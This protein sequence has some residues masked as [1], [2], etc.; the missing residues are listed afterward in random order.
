MNL[1]HLF[2]MMR[3]LHVFLFYLI[4]I[5]TSS[6]AT[7]EKIQISFEGFP[8]TNQLP[9]NTV[10]RVYQDND[11]YMWFGTLD[12]LC[13]YDAYH[14]RTFRS[15]MY[16]PNLLSNN[17]ILCITEDQENN[18]WFGTKEGLNILNK[19]NFKITP[20]NDS[21]VQG[22][23]INGLASDKDGNMWIGLQNGTLL[24][25]NTHNQT[26]DK[27]V[28]DPKNKRSIPEGSINYI[29]RDNS[30]NIWIMFWRDG[31][32][33]YDP[34]T[35]SFQHYPF[36]GDTNNP[37]R[38]YQDKQN[39]YWICTWGDGFFHFD[40]TAPKDK[41]YTPYTILKDGKNELE[42]TFFSV[43]QDDKYGYLWLMSLSGLHVL[44]YQED[45][46]LQKIDISSY[47]KGTSRIFSEIIKDRD[48]NL[49][50][51]TFSEGIILINFEKP[52]IL[53]YPLDVLKQ[54][55]GYTPSIK[56]IQKDK[57]GL[58]WLGLNRIGLCFYDDN[59][60]SATLYKEIPEFMHIREMETINCIREIKSLNEYWVA[61]NGSLIYIFK[62]NGKNNIYLSETLNLGYNND[63]HCYGDK[64]IFED[65]QGNVW[66]GLEKGVLVKSAGKP[67]RTTSLISSVTD[68]TQ[69]S[70]GNIWVSSEKDGLI[71]L[72]REQKY[73]VSRTLNKK[74]KE[75]NSSNIQAVHGHSSGNIWIGTKEGRI[76]TYDKEN[77]T[78]EDVSNLC[79]M[80]GEAILNLTEDNYGNI[81]ISTNKKITKFNPKSNTSIYYSSSDGVDI[82]FIIDAFTNN[83]HT[84]EVLFGGNKGFC[85]F[86]PS[87]GQVIKSS[88]QAKV[89]IS[90]IR[91]NNQS[92]FDPESYG[93]FD[94][95]SNRLMVEHTGK[96]IE[97]EFSSLNYSF[98]HR[99]QYAYKMEG[100][101][102][103]WIYAVNNRRFASYNNLERG[104][105]S[106]LLKAT[107]ENGVWNDAVTIVEIYK[108]PAFYESWWAYLFYFLTIATLLVIIYRF[109]INKLK[110]SEEL[111]ITQIEKE[112]AEELTQTKLRYFTNISHELLTPLTIVSCLIE[113]LEGSSK[114][115][116]WQFKVMRSNIN[117][118]KRLLQQILDFRK[119]ESGNMKLKIK[120]ND[121]IFFLR[122]ICDFNFMPLVKEKKINFSFT[123][124]EDKLEAWFDADKL[125]KII[126]NLL[127][128]AFK[129]TPNGGDIQ[130]NV[131]PITRDENTYARII[132]SDTGKGIP[133]DDL[134][135]IFTR[136]FSNEFTN[137]VESN[138]I[139]LSLTKELIEMHHGTIRVE[140]ELGSGTSFIIEF[141]INKNAYK[142]NELSDVSLSA[143]Q[144]EMLF[145]EE[146]LSIQEESDHI[147]LEDVNI[148]VVEDN[149]HLRSLINK[150]FHKR[151]HTF[152]AENGRAALKIIEEKQIDL[153]ISDVIMPEMDGLEL[154]RII[155]NNIPTSHIEVLLLTAKNSIDDRIECYNAGAD[156][157]I[158]KPFE[159][160]VLEAKVNSLIKNKKQKIEGFKSD[161]ELNFSSLE[162]TPLDKKFLNDAVAVIKEHIS[163]SDFDLGKFADKLNMSKSSLYRKIK[164]LTGL[165]P[166]E[167]TKN[168]K[169]KRA[170]I[171][172]KE[173]QGSVSEIAYAVGFSDPKYFAVCFKS[174][175]GMT[176]T[177][178]IKTV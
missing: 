16:R 123:S 111:K 62:K 31:L 86:L 152:S 82:S 137:S 161:V 103:E 55:L 83:K 172:L 80:T 155:K 118:L 25:Y 174:E 104:N 19:S 64:T 175:F 26:T 142:E 106:F 71:T 127:S 92:V 75:L 52:P 167:F 130:V 65:R 51:G 48:G 1:F 66:I 30:N 11:G 101:D 148:L 128:N 99:I 169:L 163:E 149:E 42:S 91:I 46:S 162:Y 171:L 21:I 56:A 87:N 60:N 5:S 54:K 45:H 4:F 23:R 95:A 69:D 14:L 59:A 49:W 176:P 18:L 61:C 102:N 84:G 160:K 96:N 73:S 138:G 50:I 144:D 158:S 13:R 58:I 57:D 131:E 113:D 105:Y 36:L 24:K 121:I 44:N 40:P 119:V 132:V 107:D 78:F 135:N 70:D 136:F 124:S 126:F 168:I 147:F 85:S 17:E 177:E 109:S 33:K 154:C 98:P 108:K 170:C 112:K 134:E 2:A 38:L 6:L 146:E 166:V 141:P 159:L 68:I 77:H 67:L 133:A 27:Y 12:G 143:T 15:D 7:E 156:G 53:T 29:Y 22:E 165:S 32:C 43:I 81:W 122:Q 164:S 93:S 173:Q 110:L 114:N 47:Q 76:I 97:F 3:K 88:K 94:N 8:Y 100:V 20:F 37:F 72:S 79:A 115:K 9:S 74:T 178:Y 151:Y 41:M 90:D 39:N 153:V 120:E 89:C 28:N 63:T 139:G 116:F 125:D 157:Y 117:R 150:I 10:Q 145:P 129:Y 140:S 34:K 35:D